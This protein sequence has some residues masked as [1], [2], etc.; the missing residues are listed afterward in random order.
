MQTENILIRVQGEGS[1][2]RY[3]QLSALMELGSGRGAPPCLTGPGMCW[4]AWRPGLRARS[5]STAAWHG[6]VRC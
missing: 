6:G 5:V 4:E 1:N 2:G 3:T